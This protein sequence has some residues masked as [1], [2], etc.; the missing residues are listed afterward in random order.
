MRFELLIVLM[1]VLRLLIAAEATSFVLATKEAK[2]QSQ[3]NPCLC[4]LGP[5]RPGALAGLRFF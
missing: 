1:N 3:R 2:R 4:P 5:L